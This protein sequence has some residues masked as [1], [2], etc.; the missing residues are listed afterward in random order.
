[1]KSP[2]PIR[3]LIPVIL[4]LVV[5]LGVSV[6]SF[7]LRNPG[8][9]ID[10]NGK[11]HGVENRIRATCLGK[12]FWLNQLSEINKKIDLNK[13]NGKSYQKQLNNKKKSND[14]I[15]KLD[16]ISTR[17]ATEIEIAK[18]EQKIEE[19]EEKNLYEMLEKY[20]I[21]DWEKLIKIKELIEQEIKVSSFPSS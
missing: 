11:I 17:N 19:L 21:K 4:L 20:R 15:R 3:D 2:T 14:L 9:V 10:E 13:R 16:E 7:L 8:L 1:M 5:T 18:L 6:P 12:R